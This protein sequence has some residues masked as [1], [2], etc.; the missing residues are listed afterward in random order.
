[1]PKPNAAQRKVLEALALGQQVEVGFEPDPGGGERWRGG[2]GALVHDGGAL[3]RT[4][5]VHPYT[6][7]ALS[8]RGWVEAIR[9]RGMS[10]GYGRDYFR[11][12]AAGWAALEMKPTGR[13]QPAWTLEEVESLNLFQASQRYHPFTCGGTLHDEQH[14]PAPNL[15][16]T[17]SG[18]HCPVQEC[19]Y[20]QYW[21][22]EFMV[23]GAWRLPALSVEFKLDGMDEA[24]AGL[25]EFV[26]AFNA[27]EI[28]HSGGESTGE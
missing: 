5:R 28:S 21:A 24:L 19:L 25:T 6:L 11:L 23:N 20:H 27:L 26:N 16:A 10:A 7:K 3:M 12:T 1:M 8:D 15:V 13:I 22:Y 18:W 9:V 17:Q 4:A 2:A 14:E